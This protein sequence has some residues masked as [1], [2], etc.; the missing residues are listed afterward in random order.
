LDIFNISA[1]DNENYTTDAYTEIYLHLEC[2]KKQANGKNCL[3]DP[4]YKRRFF[5]KYFNMY[6]VDNLLN[7][8]EID[9]PFF[10]ILE[11]DYMFLNPVLGKFIDITYYNV[12]L[13]NDFGIILEDLQTDFNIKV[14]SI[15]HNFMQNNYPEDH[16]INDINLI[17]VK[18]S[19][20]EHAE[21]Y[22]RVYVKLQNVF[23]EVSAIF[24]VIMLL[25]RFIVEKFSKRLFH[26]ELINEYFDHYSEENVGNKDLSKKSLLEKFLKDSNKDLPEKLKD[27]NKNLEMS[28]CL[29]SSHINDNKNLENSS[30]R[31]KK[32][33]HTYLIENPLPSIY[34]VDDNKNNSLI[35]PENNDNFNLD[36]SYKNILKQASN[37]LYSNNSMKQTYNNFN[38]ET[39]KNK[40]FIKSYIINKN[41]QNIQN[42]PLN[43]LE[44]SNNQDTSKQEKIKYSLF[45]EDHL[46]NNQ[47]NSIDFSQINKK[48]LIKHLINSSLKSKKQ[49]LTH[50]KTSCLLNI[51]Q[52]K[53]QK[54]DY[55]ENEKKYQNFFMKT[56]K[57]FELNNIL[58][59]QKNID[60]I[61]K[62]L[63]EEEQI[64][65][66]EHVRFKYSHCEDLKSSKEEI[67][68]I[69]NYFYNKNDYT[70]FDDKILTFL[71]SN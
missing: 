21:I 36:M 2:G 70:N 7:F 67:E 45:P 43:S 20:R 34:P 4:E 28:N 18:I 10:D 71:L 11:K 35:L 58:S 42:L 55:L 15:Q 29:I 65:A 38:Q 23:A 54:E 49:I 37:N 57:L 12:K 25:G 62:L 68:L 5:G 66:L 44:I 24:K 40:Q 41:S 46:K 56:Q 30:N 59:T 19:F 6:Y 1:F 16:S 17:T 32:S 47:N 50:P 9:E 31:I 14:D 51:C 53:S 69:K 60:L 26:T 13:E 63:F 8:D 64:K 39:Q 48:S 33:D 3:Y 61:K 22:R 27:N 52:K